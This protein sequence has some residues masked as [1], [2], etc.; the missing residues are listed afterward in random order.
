MTCKT[1]LYIKFILLLPLLRSVVH[2]FHFVVVLFFSFLH[3][4]SLLFNFFCVLYIF[5]LFLFLFLSLPYEYRLAFFSQYEN[6]LKLFRLW[7]RVQFFDGK[8]I[9]RVFENLTVFRIL[10][11]IFGYPAISLSSFK[12]FYHLFT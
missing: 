11:F 9:R 1:S 2:F 8:L 7:M 10:N 5:C 12:N 3:T 6:S 4:S